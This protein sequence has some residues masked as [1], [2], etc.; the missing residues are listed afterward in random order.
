[1]I[2][3][4][5][6]FGKATAIP[7]CNKPGRISC[8]ADW[9]QSKVDRVESD[10]GF[11]S[12]LSSVRQD[13]RQWLGAHRSIPF[14]VACNR[15]RVSLDINVDRVKRLV[16]DV[17]DRVLDGWEPP[18]L[19]RKGVDF[20]NLTVLVSESEVPSRKVDDYTSGM[21]MHD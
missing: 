18:T 4:R 9:P 7:F 20:P 6:S 1:M 2:S 19:T 8:K 17:L 5:S 13:L 12:G 3:A 21:L 15:R 10:S 16:A 11:P 14:G